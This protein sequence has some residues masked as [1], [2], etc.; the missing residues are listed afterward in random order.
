MQLTSQNTLGMV[1]A[2][3]GCTKSVQFTATPN[4]AFAGDRSGL[5]GMNLSSNLSGVQR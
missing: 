3:I 5:A 1:T 4:P 2:A